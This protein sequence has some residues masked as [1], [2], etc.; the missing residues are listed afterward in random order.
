MFANATLCA[1]NTLGTGDCF[2]RAI[3]YATAA[4]ISNCSVTVSTPLV[5]EELGTA[6]RGG[7]CLSGNNTGTESHVFRT[8]CSNVASD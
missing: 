6:L 4:C 8:S 1:S 7:G 2:A 3:V 5:S